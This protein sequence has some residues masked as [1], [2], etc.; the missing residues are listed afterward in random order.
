MAERELKWNERL[1]RGMMAFGDGLTGRNTYGNY[2]DAYSKAEDTAAKLAYD[3]EVARQGEAQKAFENQIK[4]NELNM[5]AREL[6]GKEQLDYLKQGYTGSNNLTSL[7][8][9]DPIKASKYIAN[10][11]GRATISS[12]TGIPYV[13]TGN[14]GSGMPL[15][16]TDENGSLKLIPNNTGLAVKNPR[17]FVPPT[18]M[19]SPEQK[20]ISKAQG[21][22]GKIPVSETGKFTLANESIG[23][24]KKVKDIIFPNGNIKNFNRGTLTKASLA[25]KGLAAWD[26]DSQNVARWLTTAISARQLIQT[27]VAARPEETQLLVQ[28]FL[29]G[30]LSDPSAA[31]EGFNQLEKFYKDYTKNLQTRGKGSDNNSDF[32]SMS[33]DELAQYIKDNE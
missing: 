24:L 33:D 31:M 2:M 30:A 18:S 11:K 10:S 13:K 4:L 27:G 17:Q 14:G 21:E 26:K 15:F 7:M 29:G 8:Q 3:R 25:S 28:Q 22:Q 1:G 19:L 23:S 20:E 16:T 6:S 9:S 5:K 32:A 12:A